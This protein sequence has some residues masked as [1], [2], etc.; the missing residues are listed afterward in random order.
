M[1]AL[2][3]EDEIRA[4]VEAVIAET[5]AAGP[6]AMGQVMKA[7]PGKLGGKRVDNKVVSEL[8][9]ARLG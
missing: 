1:P 5:G 4:A 2:A 7:V 8:V 3:T 6:K 9:K